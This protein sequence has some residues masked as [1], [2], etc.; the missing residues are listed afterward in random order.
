MA[1]PSTLTDAYGALLTTTLRAVEPT[2]RDNITRS[3]KV[4][5]WLQDRG[6]MRSQDGGERVRVP[7]MYGLNSTAD[8]YSGY[9]LIDVTPQDG[10]TSA[11]YEW[12]QL[13]VS[14]T[15]SRLEER[16]NSGRSQALSLLQAKTTQSM[17]SIKELLN[18]CIVAGRITS[19][20]SSAVGEFSRR[21]GQ[22][23]SGARGVLPLSALIDA[24]PNRSRTDIGNINPATW[25]FWEN[26]FSDISAITTYLGYRNALNH[27]Y[28]NCSR[29]IMGAPDLMIGSQVAWEQYWNSMALNERYIITNQRVLDV[30]GGSQALAFREAAFVWD[31]V[32]P[33]PLTNGTVVDGIGLS[34]GEIQEDTVYFINSETMEWIY[35]A[36]TNFITTPMVRPENQDARTGQI[37]CMA[38]MGVNNRRKN[39]VVVGVQHTAYTS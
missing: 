20:V 8:I 22:L 6:R 29:G 26:Q 30:L 12:S 11:F 21:I 33:D 28:N 31:E 23:D 36:E 32:V 25:S 9:G 10:I 39:G 37:L 24:D 5:A 15:I 38:I 17:N 35:D 2:L 14:I 16:Q 3:N 27:M 34:S 13:A 4:L 1:V 7:L 18:N 19:G